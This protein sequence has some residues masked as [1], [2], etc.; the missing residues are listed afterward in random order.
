MNNKVWIYAII[1]VVLF[2][3]VVIMTVKEYK[4]NK[5]KAQESRLEEMKKLTN[6]EFTTVETKATIVSQTCA[7][8]LIGTKTPKA[9]KE[10]S[11]VFETEAGETIKIN[12][13]EEMYDGLEKGQTGILT[14]VDGELY[15]FIPD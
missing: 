13:P 14:L 1:G 8:K 10:F 5:I 11:V 6:P 7:A 4:K 2:A 15:S 3:F 12:I 9:V